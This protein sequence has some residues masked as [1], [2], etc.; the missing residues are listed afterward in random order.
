MWLAFVTEQLHVWANIRNNSVH[1]QV[2][3]YKIRFI[4]IVSDYNQQK[5]SVIVF[6]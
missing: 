4:I 3:S 6:L 2:I 5:N 1:K